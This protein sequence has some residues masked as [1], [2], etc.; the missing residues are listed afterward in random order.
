[1]IFRGVGDVQFLG[2]GGAVPVSGVGQLG[3]GKEQAFGDHGDHQV[4]P[5]RS[6]G[7]DEL[8]QSQLA[9]HR[10]DG[11]DVAVRERACGAEGLGRRDES[12]ALEGALDD[13]DEM[14]GKMGEIAQ[15]LMGDGLTLANR[16]SEQ[17]GDVGLSLVDPPR[18]GHVYGAGSCCHA[19]I[20]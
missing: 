7:S 9:D 11:L 4:A 17:M 12:L 14:I 6:L 5:W 2:Q 16:S 18:R 3:A 20:F 19:A 10:Q 8:L 1:M 15:G 13:L